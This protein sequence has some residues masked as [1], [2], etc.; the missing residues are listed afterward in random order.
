MIKEISE[1]TIE[2]ITLSKMSRKGHLCIIFKINE[3]SDKVKE[4]ENLKTQID[5][6]VS[7]PYQLCVH[8]SL[9]LNSWFCSVTFAN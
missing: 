6:N 8:Q 5:G 1:A 4:N 9:E 2:I 7:C 3:N